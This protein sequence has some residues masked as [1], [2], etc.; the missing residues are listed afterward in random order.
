MLSLLTPFDEGYRG[1][2]VVFPDGWMEPIFLSPRAVPIPTSGSPVRVWKLLLC[3][4]R[5]RSVWLEGSPR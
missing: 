2:D 3:R 1:G 4:R 5:R